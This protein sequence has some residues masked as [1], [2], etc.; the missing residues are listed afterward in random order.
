MLSGF[1]LAIRKWI[2]RLRILRAEAKVRASLERLAVLHARSAALPSVSEV[3][4]LVM[5]FTGGWAESK[6]PAPPA[7]RG[8]RK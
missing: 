6:R 1:V 4:L 2:C 7:G 8:K 5:A 3:D